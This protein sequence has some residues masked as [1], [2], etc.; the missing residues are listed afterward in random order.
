MLV[1][2][3]NQVQTVGGGPMVRESSDALLKPYLDSFLVKLNCFKKSP[4]Y[5]T[6]RMT[7]AWEG[8]DVAGKCIEYS[9]GSTKI[10]IDGP[11]WVSISDINRERLIYHEMG[12]CALGLPHVDQTLEP[13]LMTPTLREILSSDYV[14]DYDYII[15]TLFNNEPTTCDFEFV[16][17]PA[18]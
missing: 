5:T 13:E 8:I 9:D 17:Y 15:R 2:C 11:T 16:P 1:G 3:G 10:I 12:H 18:T 4:Q 7:I 14:D 6:L